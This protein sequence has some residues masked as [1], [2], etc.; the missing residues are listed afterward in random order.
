[1]QRRQKRPKEKTSSSSGRTQNASNNKGPA[2]STLNKKPQRRIF[3]SSHALISPTLTLIAATIFCL[4]ASHYWK[5][6]ISA[7]FPIKQI[8][9]AGQLQYTDTKNIRAAVSALPHL[10]FFS[11]PRQHIFKQLKQ[12]L[13]WVREIKLRRVWPSTLALTLIEY[14]PIAKWNKQ[15]L[16]DRHG[17]PFPIPI[18]NTSQLD[19]LPLL[20]GAE[21]KEQLIWNTYLIFKKIIDKVHLKIEALSLTKTKQWS[22]SLSNQSKVYLGSNQI[23]LRF[24]RFIK[25]YPS[26]T[27]NHKKPPLYIDLR[28][29]NAIAV[30]WSHKRNSVSQ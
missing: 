6:K 21:N 14:Q 3:F 30:Q 10:N 15:S 27:K 25:L 8:T 2:A 23:D 16:L 18:D 11:I 22:L 12:Q 5:N 1:M 4:L 17:K 28:Y 26:L 29:P 13:P 24:A 19:Q 20:S 7:H 9:I